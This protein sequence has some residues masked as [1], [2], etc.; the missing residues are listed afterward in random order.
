[1]NFKRTREFHI[2]LLHQGMTNKEGRDV[3]TSVTLIDVHDIARTAR[4]YDVTSFFIIHP[5]PRMRQT[6]HTLLNHWGTGY[7]ATYNPNRHDALSRVNVVATLD[8]M[9]QNLHIRTGFAPYLF[10]TSAKGGDDRTSFSYMRELINSKD[11]SPIVMLLGTGSGMNKTTIGRA[12]AILE[13]LVCSQSY[14]HLSVRAACA[15][16]TDRLLG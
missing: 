15:I 1:M 8:D 16:L 10:A 6:V 12:D 9:I 7:G 4:S 2:A 13:P 3:T 5:S 14:N 11:L